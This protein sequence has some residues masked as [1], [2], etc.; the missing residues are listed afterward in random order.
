M[1]PTTHIFISLLTLLS[2]TLVKAQSCSGYTYTPISQP[3][4][5]TY[6]YTLTGWKDASGFPMVSAPTNVKASETVCILS[7]Y[8][9]AVGSGNF[10]GTLYVAPG[11]VFSGSISNI[12]GGKLHIE[13]TANFATNP[14]IGGSDI[15]INDTGILSVPGNFSPSGA[16]SVYNSGELNIGGSVNLGGSTFFVSFP[17]SKTII[18]GD[19]KFNSDFINCGLLEVFGS[20][21]SGGSSGLKNLCSTYIHTDMNLNAD[22]TN[23]GLI[24]LDGSLNFGSATVY[25]NGILIVNTIDLSNDELI[26]NNINSLLIVRTNASLSSGGVIKGHLFFDMDDGGGFDTVCDSCIEDIDIVYNIALPSTNEG[27]LADCGGDII[28]NPFLEESKLDFDGVDDYVTTAKFINGISDVTIMAWVNSDSGNTTNMTIAGED[29]GCRIWLANGN[30]PTFTVKTAAT[31]LKTI[32]SSVVIK[33]N[34]WHHITGSFSGV[35]GVMKLYVD[36]VLVGSTDVGARGSTISNSISSNGNFEVGR[37]STGTGSEYFKGDLDEVRVFNSTLTDSQIQ[38]MVYQ[39]IENNNG[40]V[41][42]KILSKDI[43][44]VSSQAKIAWDGLLVYYPLS[45]IISNT[46]TTDFS[47]NSRITKVRNIT[48]FQEETAPLPYVTR[49]DGNWTTANTWLH[50]GVWDILDPATMSEWSIIQIKHNVETSQSSKSL[51]L[52]IDENKTLTVTGDNQIRNSWYFELNGTLDLKDDSQLIQTTQSDLVTSETGKILRRQEGTA[53]A[54]R[55]NY[56]S[57]PIGAVGATGLMDNNT[58]SNNMNNAPYKLSMLKEPTGGDFQFTSKLNEQGKISLQWLYTYKNGV[59]YSDFE[60]INQNTS[61]IAGI[62]YTQKGTGITGAQ[63]QY[64]FEG[65]PNNGTILVN[66]NDVGGSGSVATVSKTDFLLGNPYP[67]AL[68]I[69]KFIDDNEGVIGGTLQLWQQWGGNSHVLRAYEGGYAQVNK[70]G[71]CRAYQFVGIE[72]ENNGVQNGTLMPSRYLPV[73][74]GFVAEIIGSGQVEFNN[75]QR[76]FV[77]EADA[78][79]TYNQGS[80]FLKS[81]NTKSKSTSDDDANANESMMKIRLEFNSVVGPQARREL[82]LG[83]SEATTDGYDYGYDAVTSESSGDDFNLNLEGKSMNMQAYGP[84]FNEKV[85]ALNFKS[86]GD[87]TFEIKATDFENMGSLKTVYLK[88]NVT[89]MVFDLMQD[90]AYKFSSVKGQFNER[91]ELVFQSQQQ[92][93]QTLSTDES[94][95]SERLIY[96][97]NNTNTLHIKNLNTPILNFD[98]VNMRGQTV[99]GFSNMSSEILR[100]GFELPNMATGAYV[101]RLGTDGGEVITKKI[102]IN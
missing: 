51:G 38:H 27:L 89:G 55:Y 42:G 54:Y 100:N 96:Y 29:V 73:G 79:G 36:G 50:G 24:I 22:Y 98:I 14:S 3:A 26:G 37:R 59:R 80:S 88:D 1:K 75:S 2:F 21:S 77:K 63:Q 53:N 62:G 5:C 52:Y 60:Q 17:E 23:E 76:V 4:N 49:G 93:K 41:K 35:T 30:I 95:D 84:V 8:G 10:K 97:Q 94:L 68:D 91:F 78:D 15:Y 67:S 40:V 64:V 65:K 57:S 16:S 99:F 20:V 31:A 7:D 86:S 44:D 58:S 48:S 61:L 47:T 11:V 82:L 74:Q 70:L 69:H 33:Y 90:S 19:A 46:R 72:G 71:S 13:G 9:S 92:Q 32:S 102:I 39:E 81:S 28:V 12:S 43:A 25:N 85:V 101:L 6:T 66:V 87:N 83:F 18:Q 45:D 34:E 56:W